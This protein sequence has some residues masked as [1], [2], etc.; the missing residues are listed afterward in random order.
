MFPLIY[1]HQSDFLR[2]PIYYS[3]WYTSDRISVAATVREQRKSIVQRK[4]GTQGR[5]EYKYLAKWK[6]TNG[7]EH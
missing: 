6:E 3:Q 7:S 1:D 2:L 4:M 5:S